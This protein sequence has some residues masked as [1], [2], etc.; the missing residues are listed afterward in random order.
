MAELPNRDQLETSFARKFHYLSVKHRRELLALMGNP[1]DIRRVPGS[2]W[3]RVER[4]E[5]AALILLL[6]HVYQENAIGHGL[7]APLAKSQANAFAQFR[8]KA[9]ASEYAH[10]SFSRAV[11]AQRAYL[12]PGGGI[13]TKT[14]AQEMATNIFGQ[15]RAEGL[16][17]TEFTAASVAGGENAM[18][19]R[20]LTSAEDT[21]ITNPSLSVTGVCPRCEPFDGTVRAIWGRV[22]PSGPPVHPS[23]KCEIRY[24]LMP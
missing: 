8:A 2:F 9:V 14:A 23:C 4:E 7:D 6:R 1:P 19:I 17:S 13:F 15:G 18:H 12:V 16:V 20:G 22:F 24:H 3:K 10:N 11:T 5:A 21:W